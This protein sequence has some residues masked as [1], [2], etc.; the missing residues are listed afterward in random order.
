M[1]R[2]EHNVPQIRRAGS[3]HTINCYCSLVDREGRGS[4]GAANLYRGSGNRNFAATADSLC[5]GSCH[6]SGKRKVRCQPGGAPWQRTLRSARLRLPAITLQER[7]G[8]LKKSS[9]RPGRRMNASCAGRE[10]STRGSV[11]PANVPGSDG[12]ARRLRAIHPVAPPRVALA[13]GIFEAL[14]SFLDRSAAKI[15]G[16]R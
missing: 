5:G 14:I 3:P 2:R 15:I 4:R 12:H 13:A 10:P 16:L 9:A 8:N 1:V 11:M 6:T 7:Y